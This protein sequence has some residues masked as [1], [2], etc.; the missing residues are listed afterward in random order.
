MCIIME[1]FL[2]FQTKLLDLKIIFSL[3]SIL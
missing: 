2:Q 3:F 1:K